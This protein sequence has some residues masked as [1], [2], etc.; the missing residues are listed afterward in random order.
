[1]SPGAQVVERG[2]QALA[3]GGGLAG[4]HFLGEEPA[5]S[6]FGQGVVLQLGVLGVGGDAGEADEVALAC[7]E[8]EH[9]EGR[10]D[11]CGATLSIRARFG[12]ALWR[13]QAEQPSCKQPS[14]PHSV[15]C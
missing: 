15:G 1:V 12:S 5:A 8:V 3:L 6:G 11:D 13:Q 4:A 10:G 9:G 7:R 2:G 14:C